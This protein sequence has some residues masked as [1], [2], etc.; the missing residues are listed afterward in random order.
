MIVDISNRLSSEA[1]ILERF[2]QKK[3]TKAFSASELGR[4]TRTI[5]RNAAKFKTFG[6]NGL[7]HGLTNKPS[8]RS[9]APHIKQTVIDVW[10]NV[11]S[12]YTQNT[13]HV[14]HLLEK[15][16]NILIHPKTLRNLLASKNLISIDKPTKKKLYCLRARKPSRGEMI[17]LDTSFHDWLGTGKKCN[18]IVAIDDAT[19]DILWAQLFEH[20][21]T[22]A[23][24]EVVYHIIENYGIPQSIYSDRAS[25]FFTTPRQKIFDREKNQFQLVLEESETQ[26]QIALKSL[27]IKAIP[28]Y[29]PQAKGRVE[30]AN[31]TLQDRLITELRIKN[32]TTIEDANDY[33]Q[34]EY[35]PD[36]KKLFARSPESSEDGFIKPQIPLEIIKDKMCQS[37]SALI[38]NDN[39]FKSA[40]AGVLLQIEKTPKR[41]SWAKAPVTLEINFEKKMV[42][43]HKNTGESIPF[44]ILSYKPPVERKYTFFDEGLWPLEEAS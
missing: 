13:N 28:A 39:T 2:I 42:L 43:K 17:Q 25:W 35:L 6:I 44:K 27:G 16:Y 31:R 7:I 1:H 38:R 24:L 3:I 41:F 11:Y 36:H 22:L 33:I 9:L 4:S 10:C 5:E 40:R 37:F 23:N 8:N 18:L 15:N 30:R 32:I 21:G 20:D 14:S 12:K 26:Y 19:S 34:K 29:S